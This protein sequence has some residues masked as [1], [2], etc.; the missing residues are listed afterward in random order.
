[1]RSDK[2]RDLILAL[3]LAQLITWGSVFYT[4]ALLI[5]PIERELGFSRAQSSVAFSL[6]LLTE[7]L[8]AYGVGRWIDWRGAGLGSPI[9]TPAP[10]YARHLGPRF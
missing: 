4:F 5:G 3:S 9:F 2:Q 6:A 7:G 10:Q 8:C 1:M